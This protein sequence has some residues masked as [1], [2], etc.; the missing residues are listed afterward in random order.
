MNHPLN[1]PATL[2]DVLEAR[3]FVART[4]INAANTILS[5][6]LGIALI[7][8][9]EVADM[10][11]HYHWWNWLLAAAVAAAFWQYVRLPASSSL[12]KSEETCASTPYESS[13]Y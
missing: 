10:R 8:A 9:L 12:I 13:D 7:A 3:N 2:R 4:I 5:L 6:I 11:G 1:K